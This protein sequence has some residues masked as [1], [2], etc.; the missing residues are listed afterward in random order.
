ME[1]DGAAM[2]FNIVTGAK[3]RRRFTTESVGDKM[4]DYVLVA[5]EAGTGELIEEREI[6]IIDKR[7]EV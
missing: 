2:Y 5:K 3:A 6:A 1:D 4:Q 7:S